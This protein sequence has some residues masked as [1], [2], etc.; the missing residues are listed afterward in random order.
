MK[1]PAVSS[2][3]ELITSSV[4]QLPIYLYHKNEK[5]EIQKIEDRR[6]FLL[7]NEPNDYINAHTFKKQIVKITYFM[8]HLI[9]K[10]INTEMKLFLYIIYQSKK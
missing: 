8:A 2:S 6:V 4:S 5:D 1:I 3:V 10:L 7:N 9:Q